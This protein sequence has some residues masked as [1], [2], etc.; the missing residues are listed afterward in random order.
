METAVFCALS[1]RN[2]AVTTISSLVGVGGASAAQATAG[3]RALAATPNRNI[4]ARSQRF[5]SILPNLFTI[6]TLGL[7]RQERL[8]ARSY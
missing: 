7:R 3:N 5:I 4:A 8:M 6:I 1:L 2:W